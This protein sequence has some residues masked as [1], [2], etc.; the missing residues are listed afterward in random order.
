M[1]V[2][3]GVTH[4][5]LKGSVEFEGM[6]HFKEFYRGLIEVCVDKGFLDY[7]KKKKYMETHYQEKHTA[8]PVEG[9]SV[10]IWWRM[11]KG[12]EGSTFY[13]Q[14]IDIEMHLRF[15]KDVEVMTRGKKVKVQK[16]QIKVHY[17]CYITMDPFDEWKDHWFLKHILD[18][19]IKRFWGKR[20]DA[21]ENSTRDDMYYIQRFMKDYFEMKQF[22]PPT[23]TFYPAQGFKRPPLF[24][25]EYKPE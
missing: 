3:A 11:A 21:I 24:G 7:D 1:A 23:D 17:N 22:T 25:Q 18:L 8:S 6:F 13:T 20:K 2:K 14:N 4:E 9:R 19:Y 15:I 5:C 10:W 12:E 16:G